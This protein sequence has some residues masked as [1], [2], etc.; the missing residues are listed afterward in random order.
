MARDAEAP[1]RWLRVERTTAAAEGVLLVEFVD[2]D[3]DELAAWEP[4]AHLELVLPSGLVRHYSL[5][6]DPADRTR[7]RVAVLRVGDGHGGSI[8]VHDGALLGTEILVRGPRNHFPLVDSESYL[9]LAGGIGVTPILAMARELESRG[10][11]WQ[12]VYGGRREASMAFREELRV[13]AGDRLT[14]VPQDRCGFP[15]LA[16]ALGGV[17]AGTA[18]Y[19]CGPEAMIT[20]VELLCGDL[21][22]KVDLHIERFS[23]GEASDTVVDGDVSFTVELRRSGTVLEVPANQTILQVVH[24]VL[25]NHPYSCMAGECGSCETR[26]LEGAVD[27]R[28]EVLT[29]EEREDGDYM[30]ICVSRAAGTHLVLDL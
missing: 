7:Y 15:D 5:C 20:Q 12:L 22:G 25:P 14:E 9:L 17:P 16:G 28:D 6:G 2:P 27:H 30:M 11:D 24:D 26:V 4:G 29:D 1:Q 18:V 13:L 19:C 3:G 10:A 23:T 8:E 21:D